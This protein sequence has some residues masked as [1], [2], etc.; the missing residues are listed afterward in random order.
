MAQ[1]YF[2]SIQPGLEEELLD[3]LRDLGA[4]RCQV[5]SGGVEF[6]G[7]R[8]VLY[9]A[10][11]TLRTATRL[12]Q[13]VDEFRSRD[14]PE[15]YRKV[16]RIPWDQ[17]LPPGLPVAL[18]VSSSASS[19]YHTDKIAETVGFA[20]AE[21]AGLVVSDEGQLIL[22]RLQDNR[23]E[24]S[25]DASGEI[26]SRRGWRQDQRAAPLRESLASALLYALKW[27][28]EE[29]LIDPCCG[30]GTILIE[31]AQIAQ[32]VPAGHHRSHRFQQ[33]RNFDAGLFA[34]ITEELSAAIQPERRASL[35]GRDPD[36][37]A[38]EA[39][40]HNAARAS[41]AGLEELNLRKAPL[42]APF[43]GYPSSGL[44]LTNPPYGI[45][46]PNPGILDDL[47]A[48]RKQLPGYRLGF[49]WPR[50]GRQAVADGTSGAAPLR[51]FANGGL[52]VDLWAFP[53]LES[54]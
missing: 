24:I 18:R 11:L 6:Q 38:L 43:D 19:L 13:R 37:A 31:A 44:I 2:A 20:L 28:A 3:E 21:S 10:A 32:A 53:A 50:D 45:R 52:P 46:L 7:T 25:L 41:I 34:T 42:D 35:F 16:S 33:W 12:W 8:K 23:C 39:A 17:W 27:T 49:L 26:L 29:P 54:A 47:L 15:L 1:T 51:S 48:L 14:A 5:L 40:R 22:V 30:S 36:G 4:R 9:R